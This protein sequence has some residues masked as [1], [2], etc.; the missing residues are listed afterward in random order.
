MAQGH[1]TTCATYYQGG[2]FDY[3]L[4]YMQLPNVY[5]I[6]YSALAY[7]LI[8]YCSGIDNLLDFASLTIR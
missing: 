4:F 1:G 8:K 5:S 6:G 2:R 3:F 7:L